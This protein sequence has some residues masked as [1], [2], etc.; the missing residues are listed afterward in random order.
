M[1][2]ARTVAAATVP[3]LAA[4]AFGYRR[5]LKEIDLIAPVPPPL[6]GV[7]RSV[8]RRWGSVRYRYVNEGAFG[9]PLVL[10]HGWGRTADSAFWPLMTALDR[11]VLAL[12]LPGHGASLL[13]RRF[14][15]ELA[16]DAL[17]SVCEHEDLD[18]P[19]LVA[20]S[21]GGPVAMTAFRIAG[22][23][24]FSGFT[25]LATSAYWARPRNWVMVAAAPY[26]MAAGS[27]VLARNQQSEMNRHQGQAGHIAWEYGQRPRR[28][29]L[30]ESALELRRFDA[31]DWN[32]L[33]LPPTTWIVTRRDAV[34]PV[35]DQR[36][37]AEHF[38]VGVMELDAEHSIIHDSPAL[39]ASLLEAA[40]GTVAV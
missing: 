9:E 32:D 14:T 6:D 12:D 40:S 15:F 26:V 8:R 39:L 4:I 3:A 35:N 33:E 34:I 25:A 20:H 11:P 28:R 30:T 7:V 19:A 22:A 1:Q 21:M 2:P 5:V 31:R 38:G 24:A 10:V 16:A 18:R 37:S 36:S 23:S 27:P 29:V 17:L 13:N